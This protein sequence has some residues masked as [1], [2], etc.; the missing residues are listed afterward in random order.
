MKLIEKG[1][2][3]I[4]KPPHMEELLALVVLSY[5]QYDFADLCPP[6]NEG[7]TVQSFKRYV[8]VDFD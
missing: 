5:V 4:K 8:E 6:L 2:V 1:E 3:D 7:D